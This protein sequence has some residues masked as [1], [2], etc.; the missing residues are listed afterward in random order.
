MKKKTIS[1]QLACL[2]LVALCPLSIV[3]CAG[4]SSDYDLD[5]IVAK[6]TELTG[7]TIYWLGSSVT[8]G[9]K[10]NNISMAD[11]IGANSNAIC[12]KEAVT[13]TTLMDVPNR[14][15]DSYFRRLL[16]TKEFNKEEKVDAFVLQI[17][18]NDA[19]SNCLD[20]WG[21]VS[22]SYDLT[23]FDTKTTLGALEYIIG[24][25]NE[26]WLCPVFLYSGSYFSDKGEKSSI[27]PKGS[28]YSKLID[29][30]YEVMEKW[31]KKENVSVSIIDLFNNEEFNDISMSDYNSYMADP[32]H[33]Y[34]KG[35]QQWWTPEFESQLIKGLKK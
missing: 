24:Y 25:V 6:E 8:L 19:R 22:S 10:S 4:N 18:T 7:K 13:G 34:K 17:S 20:K 14:K 32:I 28:D 33:P 26:I 3:S 12:R 31:N 27:N 9:Y 11:Y 15:G 35:Y 16:E 2:T 23:S 29:K 5:K 30:S 21:E 1:K